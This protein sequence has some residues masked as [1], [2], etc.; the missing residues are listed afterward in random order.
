MSNTKSLKETMRVQSNETPAPETQAQITNVRQFSSLP[1]VSDAVLANTRYWLCYELNSYERGTV[2]DGVEKTL[3]RYINFLKKASGATNP[4]DNYPSYVPLVINTKYNNAIPFSLETI[5]REVKEVTGVNTDGFTPTGDFSLSGRDLTYKF[6]SLDD[7]S[8]IESI[9][10]IF[11]LSKLTGVRFYVLDTMSTPFVTTTAIPQN[12]L[13]WGKIQVELKSIGSSPKTSYTAFRDNTI[14]FSCPNPYY[15]NVFPEYEDLHYN[16]YNK[17]ILGNNPVMS[18]TIFTLVQFKTALY[19]KPIFI[20]YFIYD[21]A[22]KNEELSL[23]IFTAS[24]SMSQAPLLGLQNTPPINTYFNLA[25]EVDGNVTFASG[26]DNIITYI[27]PSF[28]SNQ[29]NFRLLKDFSSDISEM[30]PRINTTL[31]LGVTPPTAGGNIYTRAS[32][33]VLLP[34]RK[35]L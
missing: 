8:I 10:D 2:S 29:L 4:F 33:Y 18:P 6:R 13:V 17:F 24:I 25:S 20:V 23:N 7:R 31:Y 5:K 19:V 15:I 32:T 14:V 34:Y 28:D 26:V 16:G 35:Y 1:P 12:V 3:L 30:Y 11:N 9:L 21:T 27:Y 22:P